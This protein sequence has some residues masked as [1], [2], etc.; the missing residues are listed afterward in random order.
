MN[1]GSGDHERDF[2]HRGGAVAADSLQPEVVPILAIVI[3]ERQ[4]VAVCCLS[5]TYV[6]DLLRHD[7]ADGTELVVRGGR[8]ELGD[9]ADLPLTIN[10]S[11]TRALESVDPPAKKAGAKDTA[12]P[13][14]PW[15]VAKTRIGA[16]SIGGTF[17]PSRCYPHVFTPWS[18]RQGA[19]T[20]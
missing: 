17:P 19:V 2:G 5:K 9:P 11:P 15:R 14:K 20:R 7:A 13:A 3:G 6:S 8:I 18:R 12:A 16:R 1:A 10:T 4:K